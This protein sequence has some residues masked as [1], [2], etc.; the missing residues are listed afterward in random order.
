MS[1]IYFAAP[2]HRKEDQ[3]KNQELVKTLRNRG[4]TVFLPQEIGVTCEEIDSSTCS[5]P[6]F[7]CRADTHSV[8]T[9]RIVVAS[10]FN[11]EPSQGQLLEIGMA[12]GLHKPVVIYFVNDKGTISLS[13]M[14]RYNCVVMSDWE[15]ILY[16]C[17]CLLKDSRKVH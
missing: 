13:L 3:E 10:I 12:L 6:S 8:E 5:S 14:L 16:Y 17:D 7:Y 11:R 2:L 9:C 15:D 1:D 4:Y